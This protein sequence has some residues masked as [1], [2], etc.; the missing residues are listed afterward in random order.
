M[1][2][3]KIKRSEVARC[4]RACFLDQKTGRLTQHGK[5]V[6]RDIMV[7][8][9]K[10]METLFNSDPLIMATNTAKH[11]FAKRIFAWIFTKEELFEKVEEEVHDALF[12]G[13]QY[14]NME[15]TDE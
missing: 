7:C 3:K 1:A 13:N 11:S 6:L 15:I 14:L 9:G 5:V 4:Y 10:D 2:W 12:D 8:G